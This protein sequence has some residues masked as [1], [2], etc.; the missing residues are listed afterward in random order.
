MQKK[1]YI[2]DNIHQLCFHVVLKV[3][4][5]IMW[6]FVIYLVILYSQTNERKEFV[7]AKNQRNLQSSL[8][9]QRKKPNAE[10]DLLGGS[11]VEE[12]PFFDDP[13]PPSGG[14]K[15]LGT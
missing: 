15:G 11:D 5:L 6:H 8:K 1:L 2:R 10:V 7:E 13:V 14:L 12:D 9:D 3:G 4:A